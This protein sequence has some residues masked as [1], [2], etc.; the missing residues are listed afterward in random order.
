M[1][2][3]FILP[4]LTVLSPTRALAA[5]A[6]YFLP[7]PDDEMF[8]AGSIARSIKRKDNVFVVL[9]TDGANTISYKVINGKDDEG[10]NIYCTWHRKVHNPTLSGY[11]PLLTKEGIIATRQKEFN[12]SLKR[13][14]VKQKNIILAYKDW[15]IETADGD[16]TASATEKIIQTAYEKFGNGLYSTIHADGGHHDHIILYKALLNNKDI[17]SKIFYQENTSGNGDPVFL[18]EEEQKIKR[19]SLDSYLLWQPQKGNYAVGGHSVKNL[20]DMWQKSQYEY[21]FYN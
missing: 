17:G 11:K 19:Q 15:G 10:K 13:L 8:M 6:V 20:I 9:T 3:F 5:T 2:L 21:I 1:I 16:L 18:N 7:H 14:G 12:R 4:I